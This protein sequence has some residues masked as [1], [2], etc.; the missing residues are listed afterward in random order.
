MTGSSTQYDG[1]YT[2]RSRTRRINPNAGRTISTSPHLWE[3][4]VRPSVGAQ[5]IY[6][7]GDSQLSLSLSRLRT[8]TRLTGS[9][10]VK[11]KG[12][13]LY[14]VDKLAPVAVTSHHTQNDRAL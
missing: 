14:M 5:P 6:F 2:V 1:R 11:E 7:R 12:T 9:T 3:I 13:T 10:E 4:P 8:Q